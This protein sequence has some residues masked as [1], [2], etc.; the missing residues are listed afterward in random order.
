VTIIEAA[1]ELFIAQGYGATNLQYIA[2]RVGVAVQSTYYGVTPCR[3]GHGTEPDA[4][5]RSG[6]RASLDHKTSPT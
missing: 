3:P 2:D 1:R 5:R 6:A 4:T